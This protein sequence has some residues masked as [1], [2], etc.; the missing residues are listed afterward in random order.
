YRDARTRATQRQQLVASS[1]R[2]AIL[3]ISNLRNVTLSLLYA[4]PTILRCDSRYCFGLL[5]NFGSLWRSAGETDRAP[6]CD[7]SRA[8]ASRS[9]RSR[10]LARLGAPPP[11]S[12]RAGDAPRGTRA[13]AHPRD[14]AGP[15]CS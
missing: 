7:S 6:R 1:T 2:V 9:V 8:S 4:F 12:G 13:A 15:R 14:E 5:R 11:R 3:T 10:V